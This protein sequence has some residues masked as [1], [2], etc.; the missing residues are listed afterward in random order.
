MPDALD[1]LPV[2]HGD[3]LPEFHETNLLLRAL[4]FAWSVCYNPVK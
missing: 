1:N 3:M 4:E 2:G